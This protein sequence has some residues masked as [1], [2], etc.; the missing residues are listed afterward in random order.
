MKVSLNVMVVLMETENQKILMMKMMMVK[1]V[2]K[3]YKLHY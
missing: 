2:H 1:V 3:L